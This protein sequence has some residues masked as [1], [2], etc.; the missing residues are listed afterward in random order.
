MTEYSVEIINLCKIINSQYILNDINMNFKRGNIYSIVGANGSGKSMLLKSIAGLILPD[1]GKIKIFNRELKK[2]EFSQKIGLLLDSP[3]LLPQYSAIKNLSILASINNRISI[4]E[5]KNFLIKLGL[6]PNDN[7]SIKKYSLGM[8]QK[9][10][11]VQALMENPEI[12]ILDEPMNGL[13]E[14]S[15]E[16]VRNILFDLKRE[17]KTIIITSHNKDDIELLS[18]YIYKIDKGCLV[19]F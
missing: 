8:K 10:G 13:D 19:G 7:R 16:I 12:I 6:N 17:N 15:V 9:V 18:D 4:S 2:G 14:S 5:I 3:G 11:I 1:K